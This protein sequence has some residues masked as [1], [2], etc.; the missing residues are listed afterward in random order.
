MSR[1]TGHLFVID[2]DLTR[3]HCDA[4]LIPV[5]V[6]LSCTET[7]SDL[8]GF[9]GRIEDA[10][11]PPGWGTTVRSFAYRAQEAGPHIWLGDIGRYGAD[12]DWYADGL[13]DFIER[14][15]DGDH[16]S[17]GELRLRLAVNVAGSGEGGASDDKGRLFD[18]I[19]PAIESAAT[20]LG[21]D[22]VLVCW[23]DQQYAAAQRVRVRRSS[24]RVASDGGREQ[25]LGIAAASL[26]R[27]ARRSELVLFIGAGVSMGAGLSSWQGLLDALLDRVD[28][29]IA[30]VERFRQLDVRDQAHLLRKHFTTPERYHAVFEDVL[31]T[32]RYSVGHGL[33]ASLR[34]REAVTTNYDD[35]YE[36]ASRTANRTCAVLPY[37]PV[38]DQDRWLLKLHGSLE[39]PDDMVL[40]RDDYLGLQARAGALF[41]VLQAMLMTRHMLFVGYSLN[42]DTFHRVMHEVRQA[43]SGVPGKVGTALVLFDDPL[44][45]ELWGDDLDIIA[46]APQP[47]GRPTEADIAS[48][49]RGLD[50][51]LDR[52]A[53]LAADVTSFLLDPT[54]RS[55]LDDEERELSDV[56]A[57]AAVLVDRGSGPIADLLRPQFGHLGAVG[58]SGVRGHGT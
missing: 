50:L 10:V 34:T 43:R 28:T 17:P 31:Q 25:S 58:T 4:I 55:M 35:L 49:A 5:D 48:A 44:L 1:Q 12:D 21:V 33:L 47:A 54:Y 26:A 24:L 38:L 27:F 53:L 56:L 37:E 52:V 3:L 20:R 51:F 18:T 40:T 11:V 32:G 9:R 39:R 2:G 42:D 41:G 30:D 14:A 13:V 46:I 7:W 8:L 36:L 57:K 29:K 16:R 22:V 45:A 6:G 23:G 15:N 19:V